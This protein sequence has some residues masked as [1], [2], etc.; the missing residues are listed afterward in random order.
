MAPG[1]TGNVQV[2]L[3]DLGKQVASSPGGYQA[4]LFVDLLN[5][6]AVLNTT[7]NESGTFALTTTDPP[8]FPPGTTAG[9][10]GLVFVNANTS[11]PFAQNVVQAYLQSSDSSG[12]V[13]AVSPVTG[14]TYE[15]QCSGYSPHICTGGTN[16]LVEFYH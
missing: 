5:Y 6:G 9:C 16:A 12:M 7:S 3:T 8:T 14:E 13:V 1:A 4:T 11:C 15:M 2:T 10:G